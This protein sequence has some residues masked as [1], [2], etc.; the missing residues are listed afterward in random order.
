[1]GSALGTV[2]VRGPARTSVTPPKETA[3]GRGDGEPRPDLRPALAPGRQGQ[4]MTAPE[5][6]LLYHPPPPFWGP[7]HRIP[8]GAGCP[9]PRKIIILGEKMIPR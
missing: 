4:S 1:M 9:T 5:G 3:Q 2:T 7:S 6:A 8:Q